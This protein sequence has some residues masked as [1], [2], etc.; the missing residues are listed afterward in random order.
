[1]RNT[2]RLTRILAS[3]LVLILFHASF[4]AQAW[5]Q[6]SLIRPISTPVGGSQAGIVPTVSN[7]V[8]TRSQRFLTLPTAGLNTPNQLSAPAATPPALVLEQPAAT[9]SSPAA[10]VAPKATKTRLKSGPLTRLV[11]A[12]AGAIVD[13]VKKDFT[14]KTAETA[15]DALDTAAAPTSA[16]VSNLQSTKKNAVRTHAAKTP[17]APE[18]S[19]AASASAK[20]SMRWFLGGVLATSV[21]GEILALAMPLLIAAKLGGLA[22]MGQIAVYTSVASVL[23]KFLGGWIA[24]PTHLGPNTTLKIATALRALSILTLVVFLLGPTAPFIAAVAPLAK[25]ALLLSQYPLM[26]V[27]IAFSSFNGFVTGLSMTAQQSIPTTILGTDRGT[28]ER[29]SSMQHYLVESIGVTGP[30]ASSFIIQT[31]GFV[32]AI[33]VYPVMLAVAVGMYF[34]IRTPGSETPD[35]TE[36]KPGFL[37]ELGRRMAPIHRVLSPVINKASAIFKR[38]AAFID[39]LVLK[40]YLGRWIKEMGGIGKLTDADEQTLLT[41]STLGW[42]MAGMVSLAAFLT[43]L[44]PTA[45]PA[46]AAMIVFGVAQVIATQKLYSLILSRTKDKAESVKTNAIVG[47]G[48]GVV[49]TIALIAAG[50]VFG[51]AATFSSFMTLN[52]A[53]IPLAA[54]VFFLLRMI[55]RTSEAGSPAPSPRP[56]SG[57]GLLLKDPMMRWAFLAF[58]ALSLANPLLYSFVAAAFGTFL[59]GGTGAAAVAAASG[60]ASWITALYSLGGLLGAVY[61]WREA[62]L[63]SNAKKPAPAEP[64]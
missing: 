2:R 41:R 5:A 13:G 48:F 50:K 44:L 34:G 54:A 8:E 31:F 38:V 52:V 18:A 15:T 26:T 7:S 3:F 4:C 30:K 58:V 16:H 22:A 25:L 36:S 6:L 9:A 21:G 47:A 11:A 62:T 61:M 49:T 64:K 63:I 40:A 53:M 35:K 17:P 20:S 24:S 33:L 51:A 43:F 42:T 60:I 46:Y 29:F 45:L 55:K 39:R 32:T 14:D 27:M 57:F 12:K 23:G 56:T 10:K 59:I 19:A 1:M 37:S 28:L